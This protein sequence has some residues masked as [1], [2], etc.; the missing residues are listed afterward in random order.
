ML[1]GF[2]I[3]KSI[4]MKEKTRR[5]AGREILVTSAKQLFM[6]NGTANVGI[7]DVTADAGLAK[8]TLYNNFSSK[9]ALIAAVYNL[10]AEEILGICRHGISQQD[11]ESGK[12]TSLFANAIAQ[13]EYQRGC[14]MNHALFQSAEPDGEIFHIVQSYKRKLRDVILDCLSVSRVNRQQLA[15]QI[16]ILLDGFALQHYIKAVD[17]PLES[18]KG[19]IK[20][21]LDEK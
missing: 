9:D 3:V 18:V 14:P 11:S 7:N 10:V 2:Y 13:K 16:L 20:T 6:Q 4:K 17:S 21:I 15:D 8:M 1:L 12:I 19:L 5:G